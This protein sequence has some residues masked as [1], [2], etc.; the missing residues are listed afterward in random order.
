MKYGIR[1]STVTISNLIL[2]GAISL[3]DETT[4]DALVQIYDIALPA[5]F[6]CEHNDVEAF[7]NASIVERQSLVHVQYGLLWK[8]CENKESMGDIHFRLRGH[9]STTVT[10]SV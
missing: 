8:C 6:I 2:L 10:W 3:Q 7:C 1:Y 9:V 4:V 5:Y